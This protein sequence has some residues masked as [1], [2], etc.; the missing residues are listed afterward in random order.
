MDCKVAGALALYIETSFTC[1]VYVRFQDKVSDWMRTEK[2][3][4]ALVDHEQYEAALTTDVQGS[5]DLQ[6]TTLAAKLT[7]LIVTFNIA[8]FLISANAKVRTGTVSLK[9]LDGKVRRLSRLDVD[10]L[11]CFCVDSCS[12]EYF[13][14]YLFVVTKGIVLT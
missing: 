1:T 11:L 4:K 13:R 7:E 5:L 6:Q 9:P 12:L 3:R 14:R 8:R 10:V 2:R